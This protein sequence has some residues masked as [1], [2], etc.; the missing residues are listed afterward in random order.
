MN[1]KQ[2]LLSLIVISWLLLG[3]KKKE[4][5]IPALMVPTNYDTSTFSADV[6]DILSA[7]TSF[8]TNVVLEMQKGRTQGNLV[9]RT[10]LAA[11]YDAIKSFS[12]PYY[13]N[14]IEKTGGFFDQIVEASQGTDTIDFTSAFPKSTGG[15]G[16]TSIS[17]GRGVGYLYTKHAVETEQLIE[18]G[19]FGAIMYNQA[20]QILRKPDLTLRDVNRAMQFLGMHPTFP[21]GL[22]TGNNVDRFVAVYAARRDN[23]DER[24][25]KG[26]YTLIKEN[27]LRLQAAL[28]AGSR[29]NADR[30]DAINKI[31]EY[32]E[33]ALAATAINYVKHDFQ[34]NAVNKNDSRV[35]ARTKHSWSEGVGFLLGLKTVQHK[36]ITDAQIDELISILK[37]NENGTATAYTF[38]GSNSE[39]AKLDEFTRKL[40]NIYGFTSA[41]IERFARNDVNDRASRMRLAVLNEE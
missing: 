15:V 22:G 25:G 37:A 8:R 17:N 38:F 3:C 32:A 7:Q 36:K 33:K 4:E 19:S 39:L 34:K 24:D 21:N 1:T 29:Y 9:N 23:A 14:L 30:D 5:T 27:F 16:A 18:K 11:G 2:I 41:Q 20:T 10:T 31:I 13:R 40:Q 26:Y 28:K 6:A 12:T 35:L